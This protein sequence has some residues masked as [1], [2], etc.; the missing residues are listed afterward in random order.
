MLGQEMVGSVQGDEAL[1]VP[2]G[3]KDLPGI[4]DPDDLVAGSMQNEQGP[5][6][7][8]DLGF[9]MRPAHVVEKLPP[10]GEATSGEFHL[11]LTVALDEGDMHAEVVDHVLRIG[12][13]PDRHH[14]LDLG[15]VRSHSQ[16]GS[17]SE[18]V[19]DQEFGGTEM[20][21]EVLGRAPQVLHVRGEVAVGELAARGPKAGEVEPQNCDPPPSKFGRD[22]PGG[23]E[24]L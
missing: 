24:V 19:A 8:V 11:S 20:T 15:Q 6:K 16:D 5:T 7:I 17:A 12:W 2:G 22:P 23:E 21:C 10:D 4:L 9:E 14:R 18:R 1:W 3:R 13:S